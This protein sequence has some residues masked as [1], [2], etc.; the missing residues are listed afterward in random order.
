MILVATLYMNQVVYSVGSIEKRKG[1]DALRKPTMASSHL[2]SIPTPAIFNSPIKRKSPVNNYEILAKKSKSAESEES[3]AQPL[4]WNPSFH[5]IGSGPSSH[6]L[7][8]S[9]F[10]RAVNHLLPI[11]SSNHQSESLES[12]E[13]NY[14]IGVN[15]ND[16]TYHLRSGKRFQGAFGTVAFGKNPSGEK[17]ILKQLREKNDYSEDAIEATI[18][19]VYSFY[20]HIV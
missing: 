8:S 2:A 20:F 3:A 7:S 16:I 11:H 14:S 12:E 15:I 4:S 9:S 19:G 10:E 1:S 18:Q 5:S 13:D 17:V 6:Q